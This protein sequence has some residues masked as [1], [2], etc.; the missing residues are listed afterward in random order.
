MTHRSGLAY[1]FSSVGPIARAYEA[2]LGDILNGS[3]DADD[4]DEAPWRRCR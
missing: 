1:G 2:A 3:M 4:V